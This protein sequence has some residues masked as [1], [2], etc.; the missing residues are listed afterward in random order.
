MGIELEN[1]FVDLDEQNYGN[2]TNRCKGTSIESSEFFCQLKQM[3]PKHL[4]HE[5]SAPGGCGVIY[6]D[7]WYYKN[8]FEMVTAPFSDIDKIIKQLHEIK[9]LAFRAVRPCNA[10]IVGTG[11]TPGSDIYSGEK[12]SHCQDVDCYFCRRSLYQNVRGIDCNSVCYENDGCTWNT[13]FDC[14]R[15][16]QVLSSVNQGCRNNTGLHVHIQTIGN[17]T[18]E[19]IKVKASFHNL[20]R[21]VV[22]ELVAMFA[23]SPIT[24]G[25]DRGIADMRLVRTPHSIYTKPIS[26]KKWLDNGY[27]Y[28]DLMEWY[29][30]NNALPFIRYQW[31]TVNTKA[32]NINATVPMLAE[33]A[34]A[35]TIE[36]RLFDSQLNLDA[37]ASILA[38]IRALVEKSSLDY[39]R[40][41]R[42]T[43]KIKASI[44]SRNFWKATKFGIDAK[45]VCDNSSTRPFL[46]HRN[47]KSID[48]IQAWKIL[49]EELSPILDD[50]KLWKHLGYI[51]D[52]IRNKENQSAKQQSKVLANEGYKKYIKWLIAENKRNYKHSSSDSV[53]KRTFQVVKGR[54]QFNNVVQTVD[55]I[56]LRVVGIP[57]A[58]IDSNWVSEGPAKITS[59]A[60]K[61]I[62]VFIRR[63]L[64]SEK[65]AV[66]GTSI[67]IGAVIRKQ[68]GVSV[69]ERVFVDNI[70]APKQYLSSITDF[71]I[72][73]GIASD[74]HA[75]AR[76]QSKRLPICR[77]IQEHIQI[78]KPGENRVLAF[79]IH[80]NARI[81]I[82]IMAIPS[83]LNGRYNANDILVPKFMRSQLGVKVG[84]SVRVVFI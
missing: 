46:Y 45:F 1:W 27:P 25:K 38:I 12:W 40:S 24:F 23:N 50:L 52:V 8:M 61:S 58:L 69:G 65:S 72:Q 59:K 84:D 22:P 39:L 30:N 57:E 17:D 36:V 31:V 83:S 68:L 6:E 53:S 3:S 32:S 73:E 37:I 51:K 64:I 19:T 11:V 55:G 71:V 78:R 7:N 2:Y 56:P 26:Y 43:P 35:P 66:I 21:L 18:N 10:S 41:D 54:K 9:K 81:K 77:T 47:R 15:S 5:N 75:R 82:A 49:L 63:C 34:Q 70:S 76:F 48:A 60:G 80:Q 14:F 74:E 33:Y 62:I 16:I 42:N 20:I 13:M 79:L 44:L 29:E 28:V 67:S 4:K